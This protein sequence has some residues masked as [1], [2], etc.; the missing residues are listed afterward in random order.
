MA[1]NGKLELELL[2]VYGQ[3][4]DER[5]EVILRH[6]VL[7]HLVKKNQ[8]ASAK[9]TISNLHADPQ[10]LYLID[11]DPPS[12][13]PVSE[14]IR[15]KGSGTTPYRAMFPVDPKKVVDVIFPKYNKLPDDGQ[16]LLSKSDKVLAFEGTTGDALYDALAKD[17]LKRAGLLN[18]IAKANVTRLSS[19]KTVL[20]YLKELRELRADRFF[21]V[22]SKE[23][24]EETKHSVADGLFKSVSGS[25]HHLPSQFVGYTGAGSFKSHDR[26]GNLQLT[27]FMKGD[28]CVADIDIDDASG[29]EHV[30]QVLN[31][32]LPGNST[33]PYN[34]QQ[35]LIAHQKLD[36]G[37]KL[38]L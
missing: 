37:Y 3:F 26:Y 27:F 10:G 30:F 12:Y 13:L 20:S 5:V 31:N 22:A 7:S 18:I 14:F 33:H 1:Q 2:D 15:I 4:L 34:I 6:R 24:R 23:L 11:I 8:K 38:V 29:L 17:N 25:L 28:E 19:G 16:T 32:A 21:V 36:P 35:I 9:F